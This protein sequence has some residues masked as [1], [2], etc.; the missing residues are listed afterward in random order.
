[1]TDEIALKRLRMRSSRRG[2]KE[3]DL[4]LGYFSRTELQGLDGVELAL[5]EDMLSEND[6][7]L[8]DWVSGRVPAPP[9]FA[10]LIGRIA[11]HA[12]GI[13]AP[14]RSA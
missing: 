4:I 5:Y 11:A 13:V 9:R 14:D 3:M 10:G 2:M 7:D 12:Q 6:Q 1:M 8:Y